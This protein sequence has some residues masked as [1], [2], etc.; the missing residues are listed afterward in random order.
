MQRNGK[1]KIAGLKVGDRIRLIQMID[2]PDPIP[3]GTNGTVT[4]IHIHSDWTRAQWHPHG[5][6]DL[7]GRSSHFLLSQSHFLR[8]IDLNLDSFVGNI[9]IVLAADLNFC[10]FHFKIS[11]SSF[12]V[13]RP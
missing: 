2:D 3:A 11:D 5:C 8:R 10:L 13:G 1:T 7:R 12:M 4:E 9:R 6:K